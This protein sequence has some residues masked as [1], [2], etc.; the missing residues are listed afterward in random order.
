MNKKRGKGNNNTK[1]KVLDIYKFYRDNIPLKDR[2]PLKDFRVIN[3]LFGKHLVKAVIEDSLVV[4]F[5]YNLGKIFIKGN[6]QKVII[7]E[8]KLVIKHGRPDWKET[9][10]L[11]EIDPVAKE[12]KQLVWHENEHTNGY[13]YKIAWLHGTSLNSKGFTFEPSRYFSRSLAAYINNNDNTNIN[14]YDI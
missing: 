7:K 10:K 13:I 14:H 2:V 4:K 6:K 3:K 8:G 1:F 9:N 11:W 12:K 5:P